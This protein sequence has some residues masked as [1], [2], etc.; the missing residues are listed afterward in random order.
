MTGPGKLLFLLLACSGQGCMLP[1]ASPGIRADIGP[2]LGVTNRETRASLALSTGF[3]LASVLRP[4]L[5]PAPGLDLGAGYLLSYSPALRTDGGYLEGGAWYGLGSQFRL[6]FTGRGEFLIGLRDGTLRA[7]AGGALRIS[8]E[9]FVHRQGEFSSGS[10]EPVCRQE[11]RP[12]RVDDRPG[13][14]GQPPSSEV[15]CHKQ[16][17]LTGSTYGN[18]GLGLWM[19]AGL[20]QLPGDVFSFRGAIGLSV[21]IPAAWGYLFWWPIP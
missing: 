17:L 15:R 2:G 13:E 16:S 8:L 19:E 21:R 1:F 4:T 7:G 6:G 9:W 10:L 12:A 5:A 18:S 20:R 14:P 11:V 3:S